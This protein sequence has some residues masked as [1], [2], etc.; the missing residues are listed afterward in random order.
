MK[1]IKT[2]WPLS[3]E[4]VVALKKEFCSCLCENVTLLVQDPPRRLRMIYERNTNTCVR[5]LTRK[6]EI[7][8]GRINLMDKILTLTHTHLHECDSVL[9]WILVMGEN[10]WEKSKHLFL[11]L[12]RHSLWMDM[13]DVMDGTHVI[14]KYF[15]LWERN[16]QNEISLTK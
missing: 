16:C 2:F 8:H 7:I 14:I 4:N 9:G 5:Q 10:R 15:S 11:Q 12:T 6:R 13:M 1:H 3:T